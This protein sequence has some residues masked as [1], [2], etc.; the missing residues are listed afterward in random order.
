VTGAVEAQ[1][2]QAAI[3]NVNTELPHYRQVR[4]FSIIKEAFTPESGLLTAN[5]KLRR[6]EIN[7]RYRDEIDRMYQK[8]VAAAVG[9]S[10]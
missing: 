10:T 2:L 7:S 5:G 1:A 9:G 3:D 4:N 8:P 6:D